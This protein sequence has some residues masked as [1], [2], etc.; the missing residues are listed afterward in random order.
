MALCHSMQAVIADVHVEIGRH[1]D[2][3]RANSRPNMHAQSTTSCRHQA[4]HSCC[5]GT[6]TLGIHSG[7]PQGSLYVTASP[8]RTWPAVNHALAGHSSHFRDNL[9]LHTPGLLDA[10]L[11]KAISSQ[12]DS[13]DVSTTWNIFSGIIHSI[14][15]LNLLIISVQ[16]NTYTYI[17]H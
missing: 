12:R 9:L 11:A 2:P 4:S 8:F 3:C 14:R 7:H 1:P 16:W 6:A 5:C 13:E 15:L 17:V 10:L